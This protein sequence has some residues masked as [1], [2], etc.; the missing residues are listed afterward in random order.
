MSLWSRIAGTFRRRQLNREIE[1][2][3]ATHIAE[4]IDDNRDSTEARRAFG[5]TLRHREESRDIRLVP[6][7][8]SLRAD[9][10]FGW[11]QIMK[12]KVSSAAAILSLALA[13]GAC[14][15]AFR[16]IDAMLL[17]PLPVAGAERLYSVTFES[18]SGVDLGIMKYDSCSFPMFLRMRADANR[19]HPVKRWHSECGSKVSIR[20]AARRRLFQNKSELRRQRLRLSEQLRRALRPL[21]GWSVQASSQSQRAL[22]VARLERLQS[23]RDRFRFCYRRHPQIDISPCLSRHHI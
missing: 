10:I 1:E 14:T 11:R 8:D 9:A 18:P 7:L 4:A 13:I 21:H 3:L 2:E 19:S 22:R 17:R 16:L 15:A 20:A 6:W 5:S 12:R 23:P